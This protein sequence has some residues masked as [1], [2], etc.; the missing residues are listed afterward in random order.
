MEIAS[1]VECDFGRFSGDAHRVYWGHEIC[2]DRILSVPEFDEL[3][4]RLLDAGKKLTLV[5]PTLAEEEMSR[6]CKLVDTLS[7]SLDRFEVVCND[8]GLFHWLTD[9]QSVEPTIGRFLVGQATDPRLAALD[10]PDWQLPHERAVSH[11]DGTQVEL[12]YRRPTQALV[13]HLQKCGIDIP[14]VLSFLRH[15]GT[16]RLEVSNVLQGIQLKLAPGWRAS[17]HIPEVPVAVARDEWSDD[18]T[19]WLHPTFPV[20]LHQRDNTV[21]YCNSDKPSDLLSLRVDRLVYREHSDDANR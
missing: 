17:L 14:E 15:L 12:R 1:W 5:T 4:R 8:W 7:D 21:F 3:P 6:I 18:G 9:R 19:Q 20:D 11:A 13:T 2:V 10:L 16:R